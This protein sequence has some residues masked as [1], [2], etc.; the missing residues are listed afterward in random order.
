M[1]KE[2]ELCK[3]VQN[4]FLS[5]LPNERVLSPHTISAYRDTMKL[6]LHSVTLNSKNKNIALDDLNAQSVLDLMDNLKKGRGNSIKTQNQRL[7]ALKSFFQYLRVQDPTRMSQ[8]DRIN[9]IKLKR[10]PRK[11]IDYLTKKEMDAV[12]SSVNTDDRLG[13][14]DL[15][16]LK[17]LYNSGARVQELCDLKVKDIRMTAPYLI[18]LKGKGNKIRQVP[19]WKDTVEAVRVHIGDK[20]DSESIFDHRGSPL[21][22]FGVRYIV[23]KYADLAS[24]VEPTIKEKTIGPHTFRHTIAMHLLQSGVD[25]NVIKAWLGHINLNTTHGYVDT[26][27]EMKRSA[28]AKVKGPEERGYTQK[29]LKKNPDVLNW[30]SSRNDMWRKS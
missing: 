13:I 14:R 26:D 9:H 20:R 18:R 25:I 6:Y 8:Y 28:I 1:S 5:Y 3:T 29:M 7:A 2:N 21:T 24:T 11:P 22:R 12:I 10:A 17:L 27:M 15:A 16:L 19:L 23:Q 4:F 30:L